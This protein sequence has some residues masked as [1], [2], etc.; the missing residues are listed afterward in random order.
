MTVLLPL[1]LPLTLAGAVERVGA[2]LYVVGVVA[3]LASWTVLILWPHAAWSTSAAG[4]LAPAYTPALWLT[5]IGLIGMHPVI[6]HTRH[7]P[8]IYLAAVAAFLT[9]HNL[10]ALLVYQQG[11]I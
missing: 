2:L 5:G 11:R 6:A 10:H 1:F 4:F 7:L 8:W 9:F 3:Y